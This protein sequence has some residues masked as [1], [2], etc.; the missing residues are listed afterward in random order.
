MGGFGALAFAVVAWLGLVLIGSAVGQT[1][2]PAGG[3]PDG[4]GGEAGDAASSGGLV[5]F[6][7]AMPGVGS[8]VVS[9][10]WAGFRVRLRS[11]TGEAARNVALRVHIVDVDGDTALYERD[12]TLT[13]SLER[14]AWIYAP[15]PPG[16]SPGEALLLTAHEIDPESGQTGALIGSDRVV[17]NVTHPAETALIGVVGTSAMGLEQYELPHPTATSERIGS[18]H[19]RLSVVRGLLPGDLPDR[20]MGLSAFGTIVWGEAAPDALGPAEARALAEWVRRGGHLVVVLPAVADVWANDAANPL[21]ELMP[22]AEIARVESADLEAYRNLLTRPEYDAFPLPAGVPMHTVTPADGALPGEA[23]CLIAGPEGC[24]AAKGAVGSGAVTVVGVPVWSPELRGAG[25]LR[26]D[27]FWHRVLGYRFEIPSPRQTSNDQFLNRVGREEFIGEVEYVDRFVPQAI[28]RL[29]A[30]AA[31]VLLALVVFASYW[32]LAGPLGFAILKRRGMQRHAWP[33][34]VITTAAFAGLAWAGAQAISPQRASVTFLS[35]VDHVYDQPVHRT[36]SW[37]TVLMPSYGDRSIA[38]RGARVSG[39]PPRNALFAWAGAGEEASL[40]FPD[41]RAYV[42]PAA[43]PDRFSVPARGTVK[44]FRAD[45]L[46]PARFPT[47]APVLGAEPALSGRN[48]VVGGLIHSLPAPL[49]NVRVYLSLGQRSE[50]DVRDD[51]A[52]QPENER[53][54]VARTEVHAFSLQTEGSAWPP[55][56]RLDLSTFEPDDRTRLGTLAGGEGS[57]D[58]GSVHRLSFAGA[59]PQPAFFDQRGALTRARPI[60]RSRLAPTFDLSHWLAQPCLIVI[61]TIDA[62]ALPEAERESLFVTP[63]SG[64]AGDA[65]PLPVQDGTI[66]MRWVYP[67]DDRPVDFAGRR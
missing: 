48:R 30:A 26:A 53:F 58:I 27:A 6:A 15:V 23:S 12:V 21:S 37:A 35:V 2:S 55:G 29:G 41:N 46:G 66:V 45:W 60:Y 16:S 51:L 42:V 49:E 61:G 3:Q 63:A 14:D 43:D 18:S 40:G 1:D 56:A 47:P 38:L 32:L 44:Q 10:E 31:G 17:L 11:L 28:G 33:A 25:L 50:R 59:M 36:R 9:G 65:A 57:T 54:G 39:E 34:F 4:P 19:R 24:V 8:Q 52:G 13:R 67:L 20:W 5:Y 22:D 62:G 7:G 64:D